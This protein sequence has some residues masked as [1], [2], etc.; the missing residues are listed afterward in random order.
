MDDA[1]GLRSALD[2]AAAELLDRSRREAADIEAAARARATEVV[3]AGRDA[4]DELIRSALAEG[5]RAADTEAA[6]RL[7]RAHRDARRTVLG[8]R[9][10][11]MDQLR[12]DVVAGLDEL[13]QGP[14]YQDVENGLVELAGSVLGADAVVQR[15]PD[16]AGGVRASA[17]SRSVDLTLP[18]LA[19]RCLDRL[20]PDLEALWT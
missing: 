6:T 12:A 8:A 3:A 5:A 20:G 16:G 4:A 2:A 11:A 15:D 14:G 18:T 7:A 13:H 10:K 19:A 17:D 9:R 1:A